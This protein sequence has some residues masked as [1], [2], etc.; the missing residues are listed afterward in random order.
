M[1]QVTVTSDTPDIVKGTSEKT[2]GRG[3]RSPDYLIC[4]ENRELD[5]LGYETNITLASVAGT[6]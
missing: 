3:S 2:Y 5:L 4:I 6:S 1:V